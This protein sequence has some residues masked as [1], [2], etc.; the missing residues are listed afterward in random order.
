M[1]KRLK[2]GDKGDKNVTPDMYARKY[3]KKDREVGVDEA[4]GSKRPRRMRMK[5]GAYKDTAKRAR[6]D[7]A[8][9]GER[10]IRRS[11]MVPVGR[12]A[13]KRMVQK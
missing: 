12:K 6:R 13:L 9:G 8:E 7:P 3:P 11:A 10:K 1:P 2:F 5:E 4:E